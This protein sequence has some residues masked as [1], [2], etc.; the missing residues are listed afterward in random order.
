MGENP[1][2]KAKKEVKEN[3]IPKPRRGKEKQES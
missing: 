3:L 2:K 1:K